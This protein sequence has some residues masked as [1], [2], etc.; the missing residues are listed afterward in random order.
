MSD[1]RLGIFRKHYPPTGARIAYDP[2]KH[3]AF[4][5]QVSAGL[6]R[7]WRMVGFGAYAD[8]LLW[9]PEPDRPVLD[10]DDWPGL[11][12]SGIDILRTAFAC[13]F[14]WQKGALLFVNVHARIVIDM[15]DD[16][17]AVLNFGIIDKYFRKDAL[18][19]PIFKKAVKRLGALGLDECFG[20]APLPASG[21]DYDE[22]YVVKTDLRP[23]AAMA[24]QGVV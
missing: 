9:M 16:I 14:V 20:F 19:E 3:D 6:A 24:A 7:E 18:L 11:D 2:D 10:H 1:T 17:D 12:G 4:A 8:G 15:G 13:V 21:G 22:Q 23:Y 5:R